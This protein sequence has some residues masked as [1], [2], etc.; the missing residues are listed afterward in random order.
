MTATPVTTK[1]T[2]A[3]VALIITVVGTVLTALSQTD[4]ITDGTVKTV[5]GI[6]L[7]VVTSVGAALGVFFTTNQP[8]AAASEL[9]VVDET[10]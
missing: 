10:D 1:P 7:V 5:L 4:L 9:G 3:V 8:V 6:A 2:K